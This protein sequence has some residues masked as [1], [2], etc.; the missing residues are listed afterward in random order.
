MKPKP[1]AS[2]II[3][4]IGL[5]SIFSAILV[6]GMP[7]ILLIM[8]VFFRGQS[9]E[10]AGYT[11]L[12]CIPQFILPLGLGIFLLRKAE[13]I[14]DW[15]LKRANIHP[16][17]SVFPV[18]EGDFGGFAFSLLG[19]F[20]MVTTIPGGLQD[21]AAWFQIKAAETRSILGVGNDHFWSDRFPVVVYH[22]SSIGFSVFVFLR[23]KRIAKFVTSIR[24]AGI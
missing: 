14:A 23:G 20:M 6:A 4:I 3:S 11:A 1:F 16:D 5:Y 24:Q 13:R 18:F 19:I 12:M 21:I 15:I 10:A 7:L 8:M 2:L 17:E 9:F 22:L